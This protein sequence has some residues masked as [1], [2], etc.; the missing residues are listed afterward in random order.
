M[1]D[2]AGSMRTL[3]A[4]GCETNASFEE[5]AYEDSPLPIGSGQMISRPFIVARI[6][7]ATEIKPS[8]HVLEIGT[9][10]GYAAAT[11]WRRR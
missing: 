2:I 10:S 6:A 7:E 3:P 1:P 4:E 11:L 5:F 8:D 9:G